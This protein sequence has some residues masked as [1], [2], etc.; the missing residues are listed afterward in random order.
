MPVAKSP[1][2]LAPSEM[3][4]LSEQLQELQDKSF[5]Q[6]SHSPWGASVLFVKKEDGSMR[7][8]I[9]YCKL[10]KL[11]VKNRYSLPRID[12][13]F[14]QLQGAGGVRPMI[15]DEAH[16]T[17]YYVHPGADKMYHDLRDMY[18]WPE[19]LKDA[20]G[21]E[22]GL[23]SS[24]GWKN[25]HSSIRCAP[26]E[27]LYGRKCRSPVLWAEIGE[28]RLIGSK[29]VQERTDKVILIKKK[30]KAARDH[31]KSYADNRRKPLEFEVGDQVL[32]KVSPWKGVIR[33]GKKVKLALRYVGPFEILER[34]GP[35]AYRLRLHE[36][37]SSV[38]D[39]F[40]VLN[41]KQCL[42]DKNMHGAKHEE[43]FQT[44]KDNLCNAPILSLA[45]GIE[46]FV[47]YC[48]A[49]NQELGC[50]LMQRGKKELSMRQRRRIELFNDYECEIRYHSGKA[51]VAA[52]AL[53]RKKQVKPR[54]VRA[55][56]MI[57]QSRV[58]RM[59]LAAQIKAFK[60]EN[61]SAERSP[62]LWAEI[63]ESRLIGSKLVQEM[64]D[65]VILI[66]KKLKAAR[67]HQKSYAD[68]RR[69]PL[70]FEVGDQVLLKV[71]PWKGVIR[72]RKKVKLAL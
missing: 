8:C 28:S 17:R 58:K 10:N 15:M 49:S 18:W 46:D 66:K 72:F 39:T 16:K 14:D 30:L 38:H 2:R 51:N 40:L 3:Q 29:L 5:I 64:T 22:Y 54:R 34:V 53:N 27:A 61:V 11:T 65:K 33:F 41:L 37:L 35:V 21:Y 4:E 50:V 26:F 12:D 42:A 71:S 48:Y 63:G 44:L 43:A 59:I 1:Y 24:D 70:E 57:I 52:D 32:L 6:L 55:M 45:D 9:D 19:I 56:A 7:M 36:K 62:V 47:V 60:Q 69:K 67:D 68:N 31:Q 20:I 13:L 25:Y 23:S